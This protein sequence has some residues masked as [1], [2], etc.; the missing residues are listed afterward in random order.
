MPNTRKDGEPRTQVRLSVCGFIPPEAAS[1]AAIAEAHSIGT[2][3]ICTQ[4][5][6]D[7][8]FTGSTAH[9]ERFAED[10]T[11][12]RPTKAIRRHKL[13][14]AD[15]WKKGNRKEA[16]AL[17]KKYSDGLKEHRAKKKTKAKPA[18]AGEAAPS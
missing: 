18:E 6:M 12:P 16:Y 14:A 8:R 2:M 10:D 3:D 9:A 11:M 7:V 15:E 1:S 13:Q 5:G 17:W 4:F